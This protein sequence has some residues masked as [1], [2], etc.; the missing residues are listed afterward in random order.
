MPPIT[1]TTTRT[2][3]AA[4][5]HEL[6]T[7]PS[8]DVAS[9]TADSLS[10]LEDASASDAPYMASQDPDFWY[11]DGNVRLVTNDLVEFRLYQGILAQSSPAFKSIFDESALRTGRNACVVASL[12]ECAQDIRYLLS[13]L[14]PRATTR[15]VTSVPSH[16]HNLR[17]ILQPGKAL[18]LDRP[19]FSVFSAVIRLGLKYEIVDLF[20]ESMLINPMPCPPGF[21]PVHAIGVHNLSRLAGE[22]LPTAFICCCQLGASLVEGFEREDGSRETLISKDI[23]LCG[24]VQVRLAKKHMRNALR[25]C[26]E[27]VSEECTSLERCCAVLHLISSD[28]GP[29]ASVLEIAEERRSELCPSCWDMLEE[30]DYVTRSLLWEDVETIVKKITRSMD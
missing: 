18:F 30:R 26:K 8:W 16:A 19:S 13:V 15:W 1:R 21:L 29:F 28:A 24:A 20:K 22:W 27:E 6:D 23:A 25:V 4:L 12:P 9:S 11:P 17:L 5:R 10:E 14:M 7:T 3:G 2:T